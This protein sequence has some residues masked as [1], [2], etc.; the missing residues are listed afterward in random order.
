MSKVLSRNPSDSGIETQQSQFERARSVEEG[1]DLL[2]S[3]VASAMAGVQQNSSG[4]QSLGGEGNDQHS[5][6]VGGGNNTS[7]NAPSPSGYFNLVRDPKDESM[8]L[9]RP[10]PTWSPSGSTILS[11]AVRSPCPVTADSLP[12]SEQ[13]QK[14]S[15]ALA[16]S[17]QNPSLSRRGSTFSQG[18]ASQLKAMEDLPIP[19]G[20]ISATS[21]PAFPGSFRLAMPNSIA[22]N[23]RAGSKGGMSLNMGGGGGGGGGGVSSPVNNVVPLNLFQ[24]KGMGFGPGS[25]MGDGIELLPNI[26]AEKLGEFLER[27][28]DDILLLD[29]RSSAFYNKLRIK[30]SVNL[31]LPTTLMKRPSFNVSKLSEAL[32]NPKEKDRL[33]MWKDASVIVVYDASDSVTAAHTISKFKREGWTGK[34]YLLSGKLHHIEFRY[35]ILTMFRRL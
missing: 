13:F 8:I 2:R 21:V 4:R 18:E 11:A 29:L 15:E 34:A 14:Q 19:S 26:E 32:P 33:A 20:S 1:K 3:M 30:G 17:F 6:H 35:T 16:F 23:G 28:P 27:K 10:N 5:L 25:G 22:M 12:A 7:M 24:S 9:S 31:C